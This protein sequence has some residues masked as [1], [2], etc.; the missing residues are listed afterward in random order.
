MMV[1]Q[2]EADDFLELQLKTELLEAACEKMDYH[3]TIRRQP[4]RI[5]RNIFLSS[6]ALATRSILSRY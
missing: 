4:G 2:G 5:R 3:A 1:D 6:R